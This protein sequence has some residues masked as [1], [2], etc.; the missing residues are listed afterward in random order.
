MVCNSYT[1]NL[2]IFKTSDASEWFNGDSPPLL[3][4]VIEEVV[5]QRRGFDNSLS[6][7]IIIVLDK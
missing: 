4:K 7:L 5:P 1:F 2:F 6:N 3:H